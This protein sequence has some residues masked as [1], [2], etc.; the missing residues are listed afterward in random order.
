MLPDTSLNASGPGAIRRLPDLV[1]RLASGAGQ[2]AHVVVVVS[3]GYSQRSWW[4]SVLACLR[5]LDWSLFVHRGETTPASVAL[6]ARHLRVAQ[7][8]VVVAIGGGMVMDA[9]KS[10]CWFMGADDVGEQEVIVACQSTGPKPGSRPGA[11][12]HRRAEHGRQRR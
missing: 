5:P 8:A 9:A 6:L 12:R 1:D 4:S 10:A 7:A 11:P 3:G 2:S